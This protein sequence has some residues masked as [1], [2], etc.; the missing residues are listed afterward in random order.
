MSDESK[1][2]WR[3]GARA[4]T[5]VVI[6]GVSAAAAIALGTGLVPAP[7]IERGVVALDVDTSRNAQLTFACAGA[8][9]E[10]GADAGRPTVSLPQG[11]T[12]LALSGE[13]ASISE[14]NRDEPSG[15]APQVLETPVTAT[16]AAA[17]FQSLDTPTLHG[18]VASACTEAMHEQWLVG[19]ST[20]LGVSTT[21]VLANPFEVPATVQLTVYDENGQLA[22]RQT[23]GVLVPANTQRIVSI[24]GYAPNS[25]MLAVR[26]ESSGAAVTAHLSVSHQI[27][28]R[29]F[30]ID[31]VT[32][33]AA[34]SKR[35]IVPG[36]TNRNLHE[37]GPTD[38][39]DHHEDF[40]VV[41]RVFAPGSEGG[42][43]RISAIFA[44]GENEVLGTL[45]YRSGE[46]AEFTVDH[47]PEAAQAVIV[48]ADT[49]V[50]GGVL[51][52]ADVPPQHDY[53]WF[54]PAQL[55]PVDEPVGLAV[56]PGGELVLVNPGAESATVSISSGGDGGDAGDASSAGAS[57]SNG[58]AAASS[59]ADAQQVEVA[60]GAAVTVKVAA[61]GATLRTSAPI[62]AGVRVVNGP[63]IAGYPV[64]APPVRTSQLTVYTR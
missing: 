18:A 7:A 21:V 2:F 38:E 28:V 44:E 59:S 54:A 53:A 34:A 58:S 9:G 32:S 22:G 12:E 47:W 14:L 31:T 61:G 24:N 57:G 39:A 40:P 49:A 64:P 52:S 42:T 16:L 46:V 20:V 19:G 4:I 23:A 27:D 36:V 33:Q 63:T 13:S 62:A 10:L 11:F 55:L 41:V 43:A 45:D 6:I 30:G 56:V 25:E 37:H 17:T 5:G 60:P 1:R 15:S 51:G 50:V 8:F 26:V 29:S 3:G 35:L 48:E